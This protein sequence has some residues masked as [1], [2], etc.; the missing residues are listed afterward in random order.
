M[1]C[2]KP[3]DTASASGLLWTAW[4]IYTHTLLW[5]TDLLQEKLQV[6]QTQPP[7]LGGSR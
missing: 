3:T 2:Q 5:E 7:T 4:F 6:S 1:L